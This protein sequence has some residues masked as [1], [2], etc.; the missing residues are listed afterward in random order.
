MK[1]RRRRHEGL[2][3]LQTLMLHDTEGGRPRTETMQDGDNGF[4]HKDTEQRFLP[5]SSHCMVA[6]VEE[7]RDRAPSLSE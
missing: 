2:E 7:K 3:E 4:T 5:V 6:G 1:S